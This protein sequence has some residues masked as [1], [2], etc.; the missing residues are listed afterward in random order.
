MKLFLDGKWTECVIDDIFPCFLNKEVILSTV[1]E[2]IG[3]LLIQKA[4]AKYYKGYNI[5][6]LAKNQIASDIVQI[7]TGFPC[8][9][10]PSIEDQKLFKK[11]VK[12]KDLKIKICY[13]RQ[14]FY[15]KF[16]IQQNFPFL[17]KEIAE[18]KFSSFLIEFY[19]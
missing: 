3:W 2:E 8:K 1:N 13:L 11:L 18:V 16:F 14:N 5:P 10:F 15:D 7:L 6:E 9:F 4:I 12:Y 17:I 19:C